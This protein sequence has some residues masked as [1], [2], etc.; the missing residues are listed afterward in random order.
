VK[1]TLIELQGVVVMRHTD[2]TGLFGLWGRKPVRAIDGVTLSIRTGE[3]LGLIGGSGGGKTTL[4]EAIVLR[5]DIS[6]GRILFQGQDAAKLRGGNRKKAQ[7]RLQMI[8]QDARE[9]LDMERTVRKQLEDRM[10]E[11]QLPDPEGRIR[12]AMDQVQLDANLLNRTPREISGGQQ[13]RLAIASALSVNPLLI[14]ADEPVGGVDPGLQLE[15]LGL[16]ERMQRE[17]GLGMVIISQDLKVI[18][19]LAHQTAV[20]QGG[21]VYE[22]GPTNQVLGQS[23]HPY[24]RLF[25]GTELGAMPPEDD[26]AGKTKTGCSWAIHC[27]FVMNRCRQEVPVLRAVALGHTAACHAL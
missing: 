7:R 24:S 19:R 1:E 5:R 10:R 25:L 2:P 22:L 20:V 17:Q 15:L 12:R 16:F 21:Q 23:R 11:Y 8:G 27:P 4:A 9:V 3:T 18:R 13:Q 6:R 26:A 14:V